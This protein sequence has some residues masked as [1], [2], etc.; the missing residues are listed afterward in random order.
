ML[1]IYIYIY[2]YLVIY[3]LFATAHFCSARVA[4]LLHVEDQMTNL[5]ACDMYTQPV[6]LPSVLARNTLKVYPKFINSVVLVINLY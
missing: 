2:I 6:L 4:T 5:E 1:Y 3:M